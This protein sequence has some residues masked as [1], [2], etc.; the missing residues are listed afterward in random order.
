[1]LKQKTALVTGATS[2]IG[3]SIVEEIARRGA[4]ICFNGFGE[5]GQIAKLTAGLRER[6]GVEAL[7][8]PA[9]L[10]DP[11]QI[12]AMTAQAQETFGSVDILVNN[13][14]IQHV[15]PLHEFD[16][17][18]WDELLA[19][20]LSAPFHTTKALLPG[21]M[22]RRW[23]RIINIASI[24]GLVASPHKAAY[25]AAKHGV[26]GITK[27]T[28]LEVAELG[29]TCNAICPGLVMTPIIENQLSAQSE[30]TGLSPEE[31]LRQVFLANQPIRRA[32]TPAEIAATA[33]FLCQDDAGAITGA[34]IAVDGGWTAR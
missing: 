17:A 23:G 1:M 7:H 28:A 11:N 33:A 12:R 15:A 13:G 31:V 5:A 3:L 32:I 25:I 9:D 18:K 24:H 16:D 30:V 4:N 10:A 14:G 19:V 21:M 8:I 27:A 26:V 20:L 34:T 6:H 22:A 29:I 2:G